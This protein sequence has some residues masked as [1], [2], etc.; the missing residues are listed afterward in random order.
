M[1]YKPPPIDDKDAEFCCTGCWG[2]LIVDDVFGVP[3]NCRKP[4]DL[5]GLPPKLVVVAGLLP[6]PMLLLRDMPPG[7]VVLL[8]FPLFKLPA[9][10]IVI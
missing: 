1:I 5:F 6:L 4:I 2:N 7:L 10:L 8:L 3:P 9:L